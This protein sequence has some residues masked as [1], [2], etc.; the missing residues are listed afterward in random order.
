MCPLIPPAPLT[1]DYSATVQKSVISNSYDDFAI[2]TL[3]PQK[4]TKTGFYAIGA[5][6]DAFGK[7][8][9]TARGSESALLGAVTNYCVDP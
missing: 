5:E 2:Q 4:P 9:K 6:F 3:P 8:H 7:L 1:S